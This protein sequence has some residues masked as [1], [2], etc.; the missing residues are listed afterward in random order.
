[1]GDKNNYILERLKA[2][3]L[4]MGFESYLVVDE[5]INVL[6]AELTELGRAEHKAVLEVMALPYEVDEEQVLVQFYTTIAMN[7]DD[8]N[9]PPAIAALNTLNASVPVGAVHIYEDYKQMYH[10]YAALLNEDWTLDTKYAVCTSALIACINTVDFIYDEAIIISDDVA[11]LPRFY[12]LVEKQNATL[13]GLFYEDDYDDQDD[14]VSYEDGDLANDD[15]S[16]EE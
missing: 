14:V 8:S 5:E 16:D 7:M 12:E 11:N 15:E 9:I 10:R 1:M 4:A 13:E 6:K 3:L 2:E